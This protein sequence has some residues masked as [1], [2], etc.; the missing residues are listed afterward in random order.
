MRKQRGSLNEFLMILTSLLML[1]SAVSTQEN[2]SS[3]WVRLQSD[4]GDFSVVMP[5]EYQVFSDDKGF[6]KG[7]VLKKD[8]PLSYREFKFT[9]VK[10]VTSFAN[11]ASFRII[12]YQCPDDPIARSLLTT[13]YATSGD[14]K[15]GSYSNVSLGSFVGSVITGTYSVEVLVASKDHVYHVFGGAT[16]KNNETLQRMLT[17]IRLSDHPIFSAKMP[18]I[19]YQNSQRFALSSLKDTA[20]VVDR[21]EEV[22][23]EKDLPPRG[24]IPPPTTPNTNDRSLILFSKPRPRYTEQ[25]RKANTQGVVRLKVSF[26]SNGSIDKVVVLGKGLEYGLTD[27]AVKAARQIRF[28]PKETDKVPTTV[29][30]TVEYA[31]SIY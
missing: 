30:K 17:S 5:S 26:S 25:A 24:D 22:Q 13:D 21:E 8:D 10:Y 6:K 28:L 23:Q 27:E 1:S 15:K 9:N 31:F 16:D 19:P 12:S 7:K 14:A 2:G 4:S 18:I 11:G 20:F 29:I 3:K